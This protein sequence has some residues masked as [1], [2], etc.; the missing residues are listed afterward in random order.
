MA[1]TDNEKKVPEFITLLRWIRDEAYPK[2]IA[3]LT[4]DI[5][6]NLPSYQNIR[7]SK[8]IDLS[9][10]QNQV[11]TLFE[12]NTQIEYGEF[13]V[14]ARTPIGNATGL[15]RII[16]GVTTDVTG[17]FT[18]LLTLTRNNTTENIEVTYLGATTGNV[19]ISAFAEMIKEA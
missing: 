9:M 13:R 4:N 15:I 10:T 12:S 5:T 1:V 14:I 19:E 8:T 11:H 18:N 17:A 16:D 2:L 7:E 3:Y 6:T